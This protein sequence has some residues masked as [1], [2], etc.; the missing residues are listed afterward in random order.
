MRFHQSAENGNNLVDLLPLAQ[1]RAIQRLTIC[2]TQHP[3]K[4]NVASIDNQLAANQAT[5][6]GSR[7]LEQILF[8]LKGSLVELRLGN[9]LW[10]DIVIFTAELCKLLEVVEF[11]SKEVSDAAISHLLKRAEHLTTLD[12][13]GC[14]R[15][16]GLAFTDVDEE[17]LKSRKLRWV[18]ADLGGHELQ[19]AQQRLANELGLSQCT[20]VVNSTKKAQIGLI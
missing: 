14:T 1:I 5:I 4:L 18:Q 2:P 16:T 6:S 20:V 8:R 17:T 11:N 3:L 12:V 9:F 19:M 7:E 13:A 15:F 10:D